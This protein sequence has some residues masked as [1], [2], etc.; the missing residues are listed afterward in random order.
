M[1]GR[2][3]NQRHP[4][5]V[6]FIF[7]A[8]ERGHRQGCRSGRAHGEDFLKALF[9]YGQQGRGGDILEHIPRGDAESGSLMKIAK[10]KLLANLPE[11]WLFSL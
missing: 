2:W 5:F 9:E 3:Q 7:A 8:Q 1:D 10:N 6:L 11:N 4:A